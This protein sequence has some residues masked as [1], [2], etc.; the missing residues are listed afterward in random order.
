MHTPVLLQ[1]AVEALAVKPD[2]KY[3]DATLGE[4][5]HLLE[6]IKLNG[7]VLGIDADLK[8]IQNLES[9]IKNLNGIKLVYGNFAE[10]EKI[11]KENNFFPVDGVIFDL[12]LSMRQLNEGKKGLSYRMADEKLDMRLNPDIGESASDVLNIY[13]EEALYEIFS[14]YSEDLNSRIIAKEVVKER[15][16]KKI[17]TVGQLTEIINKVV[18]DD[19][20]RSAA[21]IFQALRIFV[22]NELENLK[23]GLDG[24]RKVLKKDGRI[25]VISFHSLEDRIVKQF[26]RDN[27][28][29]LINKKVIK[30][31]QKLK[32]ER[33]AKLRI[34]NKIL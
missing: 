6:I 21:R 23:K 24:A 28:L 29:N 2:G 17:M 20:N 9:R 18:G 10:I 27:N 1:Q 32:F 12:G 11:A 13:N 15:I 16:N 19:K 5:G 8:Q 22:N 33:S 14:K 7:R 34:I 26:V 30:G 31:N 3:I 25:I 4:G